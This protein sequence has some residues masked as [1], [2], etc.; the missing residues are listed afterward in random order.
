MPERANWIPPRII[1]AAL[2]L[3]AAL[4]I[5]LAWLGLRYERRAASPPASG[6]PAPESKEAHGT[7]EPGVP[8]AP[9]PGVPSYLGEPVA[10][11]NADPV[12]LAQVPEAAYRGSIGELADLALKLGADPRQPDLWMRVAY[13]KHFYND[14]RGAADAYEY[15]NRIAGAD[16]LPFYNA[17]LIYG[18]NLKEPQKAVPK[19]E[20][21]IARE[22][23]NSSFY[24]GFANFWR[25]VLG[26][27]AKAEAV[28]SQGRE[29]LPGDLNLAIASAALFAAQGKPA[30]ALVYYQ[31]AL[32]DPSLGS[33]E[34]AA[35]SAEVDRLEELEA[36]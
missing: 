22:P 18:Y 11:L 23:T 26:N 13:I 15:L 1:A 4:L 32:A 17:A 34:R 28:L 25:E 33:A 20:A 19:F 2:L 9:D 5:G 12:F 24:I 27:L 8:P 3:A 10:E 31:Q 36:K 29:S 7:P 30:S 21:A 6:L 16:A 35:I 14:D